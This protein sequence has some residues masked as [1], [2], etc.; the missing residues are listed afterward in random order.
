M[1]DIKL[2]CPLH[3]EEHALNPKA[4]L[5]KNYQ[6]KSPN[7]QHH[8]STLITVSSC[9]K[10]SIQ[11]ITRDFSVIVLKRIKYYQNTVT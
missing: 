7:H 11:N 1:S 3:V 2:I 5:H 4:W 9:S 6:T 10:I 8:Q